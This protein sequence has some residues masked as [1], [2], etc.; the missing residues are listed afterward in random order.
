M[1]PINTEADFL[2]KLELKVTKQIQLK[3]PEDIQKTNIEVTTSSDVPD[4]EPF[5]FAQEDNENEIQERML[6]M[7]KRTRKVP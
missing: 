3:I 7:K 4:E 2:I 5:F 6:K 1:G